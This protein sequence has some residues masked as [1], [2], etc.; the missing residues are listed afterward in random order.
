MPVQTPLV[1]ATPAFPRNYSILLT[2]EFRECL[3]GLEPVWNATLELLD[4]LNDAYDRDQHLTVF[5]ALEDVCLQFENIGLLH[6]VDLLN[7]QPWVP[8]ADPLDPGA[9][10]GASGSQPMQV[11]SS[12]GVALGDIDRHFAWQ[13]WH[14]WHLAGSGDA[15]GSRLAPW[16]PWLFAWQAWRWVTLTFTLRGRRGAYGTGLA[17]ETPPRLFAWQA[18]HL[19]TSTVTLRGRRGTYGWAGFGDALGSRLAPWAPQ[20]FAWQAWHLVTLTFTL[21]GTR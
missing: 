15:L 21:R 1:L 16:S 20:R 19:V 13:A 17:L 14:L 9:L 8:P 6:N 5:Q 3:P 10:P 11:A 7:P 12:S 2:D 4:W 18:W